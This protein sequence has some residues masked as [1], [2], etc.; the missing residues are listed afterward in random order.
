M[1]FNSLSISQVK[2]AKKNSFSYKDVGKTELLVFYNSLELKALYR[3][4]VLIVH[5][6]HGCYRA[7]FG[8]EEVPKGFYVLPRMGANYF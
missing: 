8:T 6:D 2:K 4:I 5:Q 3:V 1:S 7:Y